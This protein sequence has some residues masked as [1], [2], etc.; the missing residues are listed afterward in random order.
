M[1]PEL[2]HPHTNQIQRI[3]QPPTLTTTSHVKGDMLQNHSRSTKID[4]HRFDL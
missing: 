2:E 1:A 3:Q 4:W